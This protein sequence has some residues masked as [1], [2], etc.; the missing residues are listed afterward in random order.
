MTFFAKRPTLFLWAI[1]LAI[2]LARV[3]G[4]K[5]GHGFHQW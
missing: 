3:S 2:L 5:H 1:A 4:H